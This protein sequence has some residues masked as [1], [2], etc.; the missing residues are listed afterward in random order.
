MLP[1]EQTSTRRHCWRVVHTLEVRPRLDTDEQVFTGVHRFVKLQRL[2]RGTVHDVTERDERP[3]RELVVTVVVEQ[4]AS[5]SGVRT[6][7]A[8]I[9]ITNDSM[10]TM[11]I[12]TATAVRAA[13]AGRCWRC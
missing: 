8:A 6:T 11:A 12:F 1:Q 7:A 4:P 5:A 10:M 2:T 9:E 3:F 13:R